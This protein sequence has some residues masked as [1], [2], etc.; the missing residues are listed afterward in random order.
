MPDVEYA[1]MTFLIKQELGYHWIFAVAK[2]YNSM[3]KVLMIIVK[4]ELFTRNNYYFT[5]YSACVEVFQ[6]GRT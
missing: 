2:A 5:L 1:V 3:M 6:T 4:Y